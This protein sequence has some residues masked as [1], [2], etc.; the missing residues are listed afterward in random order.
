MTVGMLPGAAG[1]RVLQFFSRFDGFRIYLILLSALGAA[2]V[3]AR[4]ITYGVA[5]HWDSIVYISVAQNLLAFEGFIDFD[6]H[7]YTK[8]PPLYPLLL[9]LFSFGAFNP[10]DLAGPLNALIF[11]LTT[12]VV[13]GYLRRRVQSL[14]LAAWGSAA[15]ALSV[16]LA[17]WF[18]WALAEPAFIFL[19][20][21]AL[22]QT[23]RFLA[24]GRTPSLVWAAVFCSLAWQAKYVGLVLFLS[25]GCALLLQPGGL[26]QR[27]RRVALF[28]FI[29]ALPTALWLL[30]NYWSFEVLTAHGRSTD[31]DLPSLLWSV[32]W[33]LRDWALFDL[34][35]LDKRLLD[36]FLAVG[37][38]VLGLFAA[39]LALPA[40]GLRSAA[41][42]GR[43]PGRFEW[44]PFLIFGGF[45]L[46]YLVL[47]LLAGSLVDI[48]PVVRPRYLVPI[49]VLLLLDWVVAHAE[50]RRLWGSLGDLPVIGRFLGKESMVPSLLTGILM[51]AL[52]LWVAGSFVSNVHHIIAANLGEYH[53]GYRGPPYADSETLRY[54]RE[55]PLAGKVWSNLSAVVFLN[56]SGAARH[57]LMPKEYHP[58]KRGG[59]TT[60]RDQ[61]KALLGRIQ[62]GAY[63][64][65]FKRHW[66]NQLY[67][68]GAA[69][70]RVWGGL[71]LVA[72]LADGAVFK[73]NKEYAP[74]SNPYREAHERIVSGAAGPPVHRSVFDIHVD[75]PALIYFRDPCATKDIKERFFLHVTPA[76]S[77]NLPRHRRRFDF[78]N[79]DFHF[80][81]Y[82]LMLDGACLATVPL[83]NYRIDRIRIGQFMVEGGEQIWDVE[84]PM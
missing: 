81:D 72:D 24:E 54:L 15:V 48:F 21:L 47:L 74:R 31:Y 26:P 76:H 80:L 40:V 39:A 33:I 79:L 30:R 35:P 34:W 53:R 52:V 63:M 77:A 41:R 50:W 65:W 71:E 19:T 32:L 9:A 10:L 8:W 45:A 4:E 49:Y 60:S 37:I 14:W 43:K 23:D 64:V 44:R 28:S 51:A 1:R 78:D 84:I 55:K 83:P 13:G 22:I 18:S 62:D 46:A 17:E 75:G 5:L 68:Y 66:A 73:V 36:N 6:G 2:S 20:V 12:L 82:G 59:S 7:P 29:A 42:Q 70:M 25:V 38:A 69:G 11:G 58:A 3:L 67:S 16:P 56:N 27:M 61:F 57:V